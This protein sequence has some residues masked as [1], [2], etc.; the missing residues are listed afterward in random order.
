MI[1]QE[2]SQ[3][4]SFFFNPYVNRIDFFL[5]VCIKTFRKKLFLY[6]NGNYNDCHEWKK[7]CTLLYIQKV[8]KIAKRYIYKK[9]DTSKKAIQFPLCF[10][11]QKERHFTLSDFSLNFWNWNLYTKSKILCVT[12]LFNIQKSRHSEKSKTICVTFLCSKIW[13]LCIMRFFIEFLKLAEG[14]GIFTCKKQCTV[15]YI[16]IYKKNALCVTFHIKKIRHYA[17]HLYIKK[18]MHFALRLYLYNLWCI[19]LIPSGYQ[20]GY[21]D[22]T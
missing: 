22:T 15:R 10:Y 2:S 3:Y 6:I 1:A 7:P 21:Y 12:W 5:F 13:T 9:G 18:T 20:L 19:L 17:L 4:L 14:G 16:F 8:N 11:I